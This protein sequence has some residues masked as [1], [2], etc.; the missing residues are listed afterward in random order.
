MSSENKLNCNLYKKDEEN[1]YILSS[2]FMC[3]LLTWITDFP[4]VNLSEEKWREMLENDVECFENAEFRLSGMPNITLKATSGVVNFS[5]PKIAKMFEIFKTETEYSYS[6]KNNPET[7]AVENILKIYPASFDT[8]QDV[9]GLS[10]GTKETILECIKEARFYA[11]NRPIQQRYLQENFN[12]I[13]E[14]LQTSDQFG[15]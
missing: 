11:N 1:N 14:L 5:T 9:S 6:L 3:D 4:R 10:E 7:T 13:N 12:A 15:E 8:L 2:G